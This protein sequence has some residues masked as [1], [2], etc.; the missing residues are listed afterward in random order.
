MN[1][2]FITDS[3]VS[4]T[5]LNEFKQIWQNLNFTNPNDKILQKILH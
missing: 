1:S 4:R 5:R 2:E 3:E